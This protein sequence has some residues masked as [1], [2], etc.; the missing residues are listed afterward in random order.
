MHIREVFYKGFKY[1]CPYGLI[2]LRRK[3]LF[4]T[5]A[6]IAI[7]KDT[8]EITPPPPHLIIL[9]RRKYLKT[10]YAN[11]MRIAFIM[12]PNLHKD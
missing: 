2:L 10:I 4:S 5:E 8:A 12:E 11:I 6:A 3:V 9:E 1:F 7:K